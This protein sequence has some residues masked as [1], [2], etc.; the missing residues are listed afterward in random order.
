MSPAGSRHAVT[1][2]LTLMLFAAAARSA[3]AEAASPL[4]ALRLGSTTLQLRLRH[5]TVGDDAPPVRGDIAHATTLRSALAYRTAPYR[6]FRALAEFENVA[7]VFGDRFYDNRGAGSL[8]NGIT[9]RPGI[10][11]PALTSILQANLAYAV[12]SQTTVRAGRMSLALDNQRWVGPVGWRQH[13]QSFDGASLVC[14]SLPRTTLTY[15]W[16][17]RANRVF[18]DVHR[19]NSHVVSVSVAPTAKLTATAYY[20]H[21]DYLDVPQAGLSTGTLGAR[22]GG[23]APLGNWRMPFDFELARQRDVARNPNPVDALLHRIEAGIAGSLATGAGAMPVEVRLGQEVLGGTPAEGRLTTP[24]ATLHGFNGWADRFLTTPT[25]G[26][27]DS[28]VDLIARPGAYLVQV[29]HHWYRADGS[30]QRYG[31]ELDALATW[32]TPAGPTVGAKAAFFRE[33]GF[34]Y[35]TRKLWLWIQLAIG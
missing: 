23:S 16:L 2:C 21:L 3:H 5:E 31:T 35:N 12:D 6:K 27:R 11:D 1:A 22:A 14:T 13:Q 25:H 34:S 15:A 4:E 9:G 29:V 10:A 26:L 7:A 32:K 19:M 28:Y 30:S 17:G 24:L 33:D 8:S 18:G 20:V